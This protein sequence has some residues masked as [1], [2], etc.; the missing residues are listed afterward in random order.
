MAIN[1]R[2]FVRH[3]AVD[4]SVSGLL[5]RQTPML[6]S[7]NTEG[8]IDCQPDSSSASQGAALYLDYG[9]DAQTCEDGSLEISERG[10]CFRARWSFDIGAEL[11]V[12]LVYDHPRLGTRRVLVEGTV[13]RCEN[14]ATGGAKC[15]DTT[16]L[17]LDLPEELRQG[18]REFSYRLAGAS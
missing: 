12:A 10:M 18:L 11:S 6:R 3:L 14:V 13:V 9:A 4:S 1:T 15:Y 5:T 2:E 16:I 17:F 8:M 7:E